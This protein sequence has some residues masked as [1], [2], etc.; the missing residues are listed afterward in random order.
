[1]PKPP[2]NQNNRGGGGPQNRFNIPNWVIT[3]LILVFVFIFLQR[4]STLVLDASASPTEI[5]YSFFRQQAEAGKVKSVTFT[6]KQ[7]QG[8]FT[9]PIAIT[10]SQTNDQSAPVRTIQKFT[11]YLPTIEDAALM[12]LL[13]TN[14]GVKIEAVD[15]SP[16]TWLLLLVNWGPL[17]VIGILLYV[18]FIRARQQQSNIFGFGQSRARR[19]NEEM[20]QVTFEDVA[21]EEAAK[22]ELAEMVDFLKDPDKYLRLGARIPRGVLLIGP[23]GTGKTLM[24][25]AVAGEAKVPFFS[26]SASEF[27]EMFVGVGASRV[28]DLFGRAKASAPCIIF[29]DEIDAVGRQ[30][31]AGLGGGND[32]R[33]QTL[34]QLL[35]EM[36]GFDQRETIIIMAATNRP[37]VLDPALLRPGR[38]DRQVTLGLPDRNGRHA[39][40]K[41][42]TKHMPLAQEVD[43][44]KLAQ[45]TMG[46]SGADLENLSNEAALTAARNKRDKVIMRDFEVSLD[47]IILGSE[48]PPLSDEKERKIVAYHEGGHALAAALTPDADPILKVSIVPRGRAL[49]V[50]QSAP[51]DD[52]RNYPK[53][54][55]M[56]RLV[57]ALGG[58]SSEEIALGSITTGA[59]NDLRQATYLARM[60]VA[61][62]GMNEEF[63]PINYGDQ[64]QQPFLGYTMTQPRQYSD[65]TAALIDKE[66]KRLVEQAHERAR[67][68]MRENRA[69]LDSIAKELMENEIV[70]AARIQELIKQT[71]E[72]SALS[73]GVA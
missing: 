43:L 41:V 32:E 51:I 46:F 9:E 70:D 61:Q 49:G 25:R 27:V 47:R 33:E 57:V 15:P 64:E 71:Q 69:A 14:K 73:T 60:M 39:I 20:P 44:L 53:E 3:L 7:V 34:N 23:P 13:L 35:V 10:P 28:R 50:M 30:R 56:A 59:E 52:R 2:N 22:G 62:L 72:Q 8:E 42:H 45:A 16:P 67:Q 37:D 54:Y 31:G 21:G 36:D 65:Q 12:Q 58:R 5:A 1:M 19:Y 63:G 66:T 6:D 29:I 40:L 26:L 17:I 11:T 4:M 55:L 18:F 38:F 48:R 24:A 68:I